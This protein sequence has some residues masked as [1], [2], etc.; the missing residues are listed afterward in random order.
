MFI[1]AEFAL[2]VGNIVPSTK[3]ALAVIV[4]R[5]D[6]SSSTD[7]DNGAVTAGSII[8][9]YSLAGLLGLDGVTRAPR[10]ASTSVAE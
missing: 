6:Q 2:S 9:S 4:F 8:G 5:M 1:D 3:T 10:G 7:Q